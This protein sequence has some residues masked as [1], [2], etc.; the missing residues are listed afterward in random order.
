MRRNPRTAASSGFRVVPHGGIV[1]GTPHLRIFISYR[2]SDS[3]AAARQLGHALIERFGEANVFLDTASLSVGMSWETQIAERV[4]DADVVLAVIGREWLA[5]SDERGRRQLLDP[6]AEDVLRVELETAMRG[7]PHVVPVLVDDAQMPLRDSLPRPFR[8]VTRMQA[9]T[10][11]HEDWD[12]DVEVLID[13]LIRLGPPPPAPDAVIAQ[14][15]P[16]ASR[17]GA[18][19]RLRGR[20]QGALRRRRGPS[21]PRDGRPAGRAGRE[22]RRRA[23]GVRAWRAAGR[24]GAGD[25]PQPVLQGRAGARR[26]RARHAADLRDGRRRRPL[27]RAAGGADQGEVAA[28]PRAAV[29]RRRAGAAARPRLR[30]VPDDHHDELRHRAGAGLRCGAR[31]VRPRRVHGRGGARGP[32]PPRARGGT[33]RAASH[34]RS[35]CPTATSASRWTTRTTWSAP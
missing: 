13:E 12:R 21:P 6:H 23:V 9:R 14:P 26:P 24:G 29:P 33:T 11:R 10:L 1:D 32:L 5:T 27:P 3:Q 35:R 30:A 22:R 15:P 7:R 34:S 17:A 20:G 31:A 2:R 16:P 4:R 25:L 28:R 19:Q 18:G 8:P